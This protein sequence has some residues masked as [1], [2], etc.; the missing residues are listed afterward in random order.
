MSYEDDETLSTP[1]VTD[2]DVKQLLLVSDPLKPASSGILHPRI[3]KDVAEKPFGPLM[4]T[5]SGF[6]GIREIPKDWIEM[7]TVPVLTEG[8]W[9]GT[10]M[11]PDFLAQG[12]TMQCTA[13]TSA[14]SERGW[15]N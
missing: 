15:C 7:D 6:G 5:F 3:Q 13:S 2:E 4:V 12:G 1:T 9:D 10:S 8:R 11:C 14:T